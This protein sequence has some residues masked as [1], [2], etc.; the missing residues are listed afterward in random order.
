MPKSH[1]TP[2]QTLP[3][4]RAILDTVQSCAFPPQQRVQDIPKVSAPVLDLSEDDSEAPGTDGLLHPAGETLQ[5]A[6]ANLCR[7]SSRL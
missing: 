5:V 6:N 1:L 2:S 3:F 4:I 7:F